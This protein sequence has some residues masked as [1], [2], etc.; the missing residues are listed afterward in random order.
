MNGIFFAQFFLVL[1]GIRSCCLWIGKKKKQF[2]TV[3]MSCIVVVY[4]FCGVSFIRFYF[5]EYKTLFAPQ[6]LFYDTYEDALAHLEDAV[7]L[8]DRTIYVKD[9]Y[10]Y[11][12]LTTKISP[13]DFNLPENGTETYENVVF[14]FPETYDPNGVYLVRDTN[15]YR[16][17]VEQYT[18]ERYREGMYIC[19]YE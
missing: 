9:S 13:Y 5:T 12:L 8:D 16:E 7:D 6:Y 15:G 11:Y 3:L 17:V 19:Y 2:A 1:W 10:I 4:A 14:S 18:K